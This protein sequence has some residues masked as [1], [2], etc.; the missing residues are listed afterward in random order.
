MSLLRLAGRIEQSLSDVCAR[1][2]ITHDQYNVMR[3]LRGAY[4]EGLPRFEISQRLINR[5]PDVTRLLDRLGRG[6]LIER[7]GSPEDRRLSLSRI[8]ESGLALLNRLDPE[9][10]AVHEAVA[11]GLS[12]N[13]KQE[14]GR[15][16]GAM[17]R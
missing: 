15:L 9:V 7:V 11:M 4:P 12:D 2:G 14:L 6:G 16:C 17:L 13:E 8:T 1:H 3:I 10:L 5:A